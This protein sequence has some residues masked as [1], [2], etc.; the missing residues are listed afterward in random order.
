MT[1]AHKV[2]AE[3]E[4]IIAEKWQHYFD[5]RKYRFNNSFFRKDLNLF[6]YSCKFKKKNE[7]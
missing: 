5:I 2:S 6:S 4:S 3:R 1:A 7:K